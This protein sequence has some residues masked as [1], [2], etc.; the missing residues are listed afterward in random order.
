MKEITQF[1][2]HTVEIWRRPKQRH[3]NLRVRPDGALRV[4]CGLKVP[5]RDIFGFIRESDGFIKKSLA[6]L[7]EFYRKHPPKKAQ[8]GEPYLYFGE[9]FPLQLVW[10]WKPKIKVQFRDGEFEMTAPTDSGAEERRLAIQKFFK[11]EGA[12]YLRACSDFWAQKMNLQPMSVSI[13]GQ[14][15]RWGSCTSRGDI[16]LNWKLLAVPPDVIDYVVIHE[17]AHLI[18]MD[19]SPR[20]WNLVAEYFPDHK[21]AKRWLREHEPELAVQFK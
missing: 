10:T 12:K 13:R 14:T 19:H 5:K 9:R 2:N 4:T 6:D 15:S 20:F 7:A 21:R 3:I 8:T 16:N 1:E 11:R 18:H 17:L